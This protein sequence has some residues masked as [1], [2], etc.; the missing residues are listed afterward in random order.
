MH[1]LLAES[2][3]SATRERYRHDVVVALI[4]R[5]LDEKRMHPRQDGLDESPRELAVDV[6]ARATAELGW[7][8]RRVINATGTILHTGLGRA[9]LSDA[10]LEALGRVAS[11]CD[12]ELEI[13]TGKRGSRQH[14][15]GS[16]ITLLLGC[17]RAMV[18][19]N[20]AAAVFLTLAALAARRE[21]IVSRGEAVEIGGG[22]RVPE[23]LRQSGAKLVE[24]GTT[25]RTTRADYESAIGPRT[26]AILRVHTSNFRIVGFTGSPPAAD[27]ADLAHS[28]G[29]SLIIDNGSGPLIDTATFG[30]AHEPM[31]SEAIAAGAD[32]VTFS[33]D[34]LLGGPQ[35][36]VIAGRRDLVEGLERH[37][38]ARALRP[39]KTALA[40]LQAT[41]CQYAMGQEHAIPIVAMMSESTDSL[42][43]RAVRVATQLSREGVRVSLEAGE[44][45]VGG[46]S[47]PGETLPTWLLMVSGAS[48]G[49]LNAK[50]RGGSTAVIGRVDRRG[51]LLDI[52]T[53]LP[54]EEHELGLA[55]VAAVRSLDGGFGTA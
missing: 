41:L 53:V 26:A 13:E 5:I 6:A 1:A 47:L 54:R 9:P 40:A 23:I 33:T 27:L 34:K 51:C 18:V 12:L 14:H 19:V 35:G 38:L 16:I 4:R 11:Y 36:G 52:R 3:L 8:P 44:S 30:L 46:G 50:L 10:A 15:L 48:S 45:A 22:F 29:I 17:Q 39:D 32:L 21:V 43:E 28:R 24:V 42:R 25:N 37:Q 7:R 31:P 2:S 55:I 49:R 20:N